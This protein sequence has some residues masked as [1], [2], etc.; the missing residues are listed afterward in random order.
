MTVGAPG[1]GKTT[2]ARELSETTGAKRI[3]L[4]EIRAEISGD[5]SD[6]SASAEAFAIADDRAR[7]DLAERHS[8]IVDATHANAERRS[9]DIRKYRKLGARTV[10]AL[11][12]DIP[13]GEIYLRNVERGV[14]V[15]PKTGK[16]GRLVPKDVVDRMLSSLERKPPTEEEGF[17]EVISIAGED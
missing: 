2:V 8:I 1:S 11:Y 17:D 9:R 7:A 5:E 13:T 6:Q 14:A 4:D 12:F 15:D 3:S 10:L 16:P